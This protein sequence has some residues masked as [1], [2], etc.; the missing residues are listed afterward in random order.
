MKKHSAG[1]GVTLFDTLMTSYLAAVSKI[2][3]VKPQIEPVQDSYW[4]KD[5]TSYQEAPQTSSKARKDVSQPSSNT[6]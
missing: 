2:I 4:K 5:S 6:H 3:S 1:E